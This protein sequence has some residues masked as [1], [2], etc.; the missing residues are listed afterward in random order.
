[1]LAEELAPGH[2]VTFVEQ[3]IYQ[4]DGGQHSGAL[5]AHPANGG[6]QIAGRAVTRSQA[7]EPGCAAESSQQL[8]HRSRC[9]AR[10]FTP[11]M[12]RADL[13][14]TASAPLRRCV[15][16]SRRI[17][18]PVKTFTAVVPVHPAPARRR[19]L[20]ARAPP[21]AVRTAAAWCWRG[22]D[23][24]VAATRTTVPAG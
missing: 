23:E 22:G 14:V 13:P 7:E 8:R 21:D 12:L 6:H 9:I 17:S 16:N 19:R 15:R 5:M 11:L 4:P 10:I 18:Q 1:M 2:L 3:F 24:H 20:S